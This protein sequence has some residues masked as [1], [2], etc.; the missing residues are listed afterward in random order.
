MTL[1]NEEGRPVVGIMTPDRT[2]W[3]VGEPLGYGRNY[4]VTATARGGGQG[5]SRTGS[6]TTLTPDNQ[7]GVTLQTTG[8]TPLSTG[9]TYGVGIVIVAHFDEPIGDRAAAERR[10]SVRTTPGVEGSWYWLDDQ[11]AHWRPR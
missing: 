7:A 9:G 8:G 11:N 6:F 5:A 1:V 3:K 4:T 2:S 10:L